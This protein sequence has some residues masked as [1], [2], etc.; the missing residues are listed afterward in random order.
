MLTH[1]LW[2]RGSVAGPQT[3]RRGIKG[4]PGAA[5]SARVNRGCIVFAGAILAAP[6]GAA[7][8]ALAR[9][10]GSAPAQHGAVRLEEGTP[11]PYDE[12]DEDSMTGQH[13]ISFAYRD[14]SGRRV[15]GYTSITTPGECPPRARSR[16]RPS[17]PYEAQP[18]SYCI[19]DTQGD[20]TWHYVP[21]PARP[22]S[23]GPVSAGQCPDLL[24]MP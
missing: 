24:S 23:L 12:C 22:D 2:G 8:F 14:E 17:P 10:P 1:C 15:A 16:R 13:T 6:A 18:S 20:G 21:S 3:I 19:Q 4:S 9:P 11:V 7:I 5:D